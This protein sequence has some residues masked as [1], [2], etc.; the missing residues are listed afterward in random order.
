MISDIAYSCSMK[1]DGRFSIEWMTGATERISGYSIEEIA[2]QGCWH[3]LV[4]EE[5]QLPF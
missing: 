3:F 4:I 1:E 5:D 2:A